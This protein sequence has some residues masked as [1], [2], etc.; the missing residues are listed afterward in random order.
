V[1]SSIGLPQVVEKVGFM[2]TI[3]K[4]DVVFSEVLAQEELCQV[5][6][7]KNTRVHVT[8]NPEED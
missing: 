2:N 1:Q 3:Y 6:S 4:S 8:C 7:T 5:A